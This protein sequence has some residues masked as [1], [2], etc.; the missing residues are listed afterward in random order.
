MGVRR[1]VGAAAVGFMVAAALSADFDVANRGAR[2]ECERTAEFCLPIGYYAGGF[3]VAAIIVAALVPLGFRLAGLGRGYIPV[4]VLLPFVVEKLS[5][6]NLVGT[7]HPLARYLAATAIAFGLLG[8][9]A[10][11]LESSRG[12]QVE[13]LD[14]RRAA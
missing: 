4:G 10:H 5:G 1:V 3:G 2:G 12:S 8:L 9:V 14:D 6:V 13:D 7:V 11:G